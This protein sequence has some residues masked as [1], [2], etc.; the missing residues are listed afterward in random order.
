MSIRYIIS[1]NGETII[2]ELK[3]NDSSKGSNKEITYTVDSTVKTEEVFLVENNAGQ[4]LINTENGSIINNI[5]VWAENSN[6]SGYSIVADSTQPVTMKVRCV[7]PVDYTKSTVDADGTIKD[8][9]AKESLKAVDFVVYDAYTNK[10][11]KTIAAEYDS[12]TDTFSAQME[13]I[14]DAAG[15]QI[16]YACYY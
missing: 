15:K 1:I 11:L 3:L 9:A 5:Q 16:V 7:A 2:K 10:E 13:G 14:F 12:A 6:Y 4:I 8:E